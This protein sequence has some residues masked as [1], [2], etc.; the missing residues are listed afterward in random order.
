MTNE[1]YP[2]LWFDGQALA[3]ADFY[4][5]IFHQSRII[6]DTPMVV[7]FEINGKKIMGIN[8]SPMF[9][10]NPSIS[11]FLHC[12]SIE[13]CDRIWNGLSVGATILMAMDKYP[14]SEQ[15]GWLQDKFGFT[16]QVMKSDNADKMMPAMLF[17][18]K[19]MG[20]AVEALDFYTNTFKNSTIE[21][22]NFYPEGSPYEGSISYAE[23][24]I[25]SYPLVA[26][27]GPNEHDFTFN[28]GV[29]FVL[30]CKNQD[31]IDYFWNTFTKE[32]GEESMCGW[33]KDKYGIFWQVIPHN[34]GALINNSD[35]G[36]RAIQA[37]L[38]M[39]KLDLATLEN[40]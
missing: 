28:E 30:N 40:A 32:G 39:K 36:S 4:C 14:W 17:T 38:K 8:G 25:D 34:M 26:M 1:I 21:M 24:N 18:G 2:C 33:C 22:K 6:S 7:M 16:W 11:M 37:M 9:K 19:Q 10:M 13:E 31:E 27:D 5:S 29:S 12:T 15:Y 35:K 3:A 23:F 20:K